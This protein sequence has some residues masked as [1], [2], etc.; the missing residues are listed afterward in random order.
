MEINEYVFI[1]LQDG[2]KFIILMW[3]N[4][5]FF[6]MEYL[7]YDIIYIE[8]FTRNIWIFEFLII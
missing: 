6:F 8:L 1:Y 4:F 7:L 3:R 5:V 2:N